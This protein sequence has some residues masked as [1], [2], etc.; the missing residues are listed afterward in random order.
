LILWDSVSLYSLSLELSLSSCLHIPSTGREL[1]PCSALMFYFLIWSWLQVSSFCENFSSYTVQM[2]VLLYV[3][4][5]LQWKVYLGNNF[6]G[7]IRSTSD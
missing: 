2:C 6:Y 3:Y 4:L 5:K 1:P 7:K